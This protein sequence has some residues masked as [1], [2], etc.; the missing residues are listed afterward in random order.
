MLIAARLCSLGASDYCSAP[1]HARR[2]VCVA[3]L[4]RGRNLARNHCTRSKIFKWKYDECGYSYGRCS[5]LTLFKRFL[6]KCV[7][8][9]T[10]SASFSIQALA[11]LSIIMN[12]RCFLFLPH[13]HLSIVPV[14]KSITGPKSITFSD[15]M[16]SSIA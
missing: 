1:G 10:T 4:R 12:L 11:P 3:L 7:L 8:L 5:L 6:L 9:F 13:L 16:V 14:V 2:L 15:R